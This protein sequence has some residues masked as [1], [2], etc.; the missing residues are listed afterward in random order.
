[1]FLR[2]SP[3]ILLLLFAP[4]IALALA[5][6]S[7]APKSLSTTPSSPSQ[8]P[9]P[10]DDGSQPS[11]TTDQSTS[12]S[13]SPSA[14]TGSSLVR[15]GWYPGWAPAAVNPFPISQIPWGQY[16]VMTWAFAET[17]SDVSTISLPDPGLPDFVAAAKNNS[18]KASLSIGGWSGSVYYSTAVATPENRTA[19]VKAITD[20]VSQYQLDGIDF[21]WEFPG[22]STTGL[23]GNLF[24]VND[25][26][27][28][29]L[30]LQELR[31]DPIGSTLILTAT[32]TAPFLGSDSQPMSDVSGFSA[33]LDRIAIMAYDM[34]G[35]WSSN[36]GPNA[37][38]NDVCAP[39]L[40]QEGS[41]TT[42]VNM[43]T[44][45]SFP[46]N[47][48][49]LGVPSYGHSFR[50][51]SSDALQ[52]NGTIAMYPTVDRNSQ[53]LGNSDSANYTITK[54][55]CGNPTGGPSG[56]FTFEG[57]IADGF[58]NS[59]GTAA[60]GI[61]YLS[62]PCS[63]TPVLYNSSSHVMVSYD[64]V[65][66]FAAKGSFITEKQ[67]AG[68]AVWDVTGDSTDNLLLTSINKAIGA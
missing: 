53:P 51:A 19:F 47:K 27:N 11:P 42:L 9:S 50:V 65:E 40:E 20:L 55:A 23:C 13:P 38:L 57:L 39:P 41:A 29:L 18:V 8:D 30:L 28:F 15:S 5:P 52:S 44:N 16:D 33:V 37:P 1:M 61:N 54:D 43:W 25:T 58:L 21:D 14:T 64:D 17:T 59:D 32:A 4:R 63:K 46:S 22:S 68:F 48:I 26:A 45:A 66:S 2:T 7:C 60:T 49:A 35:A 67:L 10:T 62:D 6:R 3:S 56:I 31:K 24:N 36:A 34:F 12:S